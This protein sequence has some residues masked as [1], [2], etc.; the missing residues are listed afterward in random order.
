MYNYSFSLYST[1]KSTISKMDIYKNYALN[2]NSDN[3]ML[4]PFATVK[5]PCK[6]NTSHCPVCKHTDPDS[7]RSK[8]Q[9][10]DKKYTQTESADPHRTAGCDHGKFYI[11]GSSKPISGYECHDPYK[12]LYNC[13]PHH[14]MKTHI[15]TFFFHTTKDCDWFCQC[16]YTKTAYDDNNFCDHAEFFYVIDCFILS[17]GT[18]TLTDDRHQTDSDSDCCN[19]I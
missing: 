6:N 16:K 11:A 5:S 3:F 19:T 14:H 1:T 13:D 7:H 15:C 9:S 2:M 17:S 18:K 4:Q 12:R 8:S 10:S